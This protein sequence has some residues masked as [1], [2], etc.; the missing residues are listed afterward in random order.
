MSTITT[1]QLRENMP[2]VIRDLRLG[3]SVQLSYR[4]NIIGVLTP[5]AAAKQTYRAGSPEAIRKSLQNLKEANLID[6][7]GNETSNLK[8]Q[9]AEIRETKYDSK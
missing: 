8:K 6:N 9:I 7:D 2:S 5:I 3:K 4:H 1:K